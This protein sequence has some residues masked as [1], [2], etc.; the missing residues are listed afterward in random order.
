MNLRPMALGATIFMLTSGA[1]IA[2]PMP[3]GPGMMSGGHHMAQ[4]RPDPATIAKNHADHLR[5]A[6]QLTP[7]QEP[8]LAAL[9]ASMKPPAD[10][11]DGMEGGHDAMSKL[12]T[13]QRLDKMLA[14][15]DEHRAAMVDHVA[16]IKRFYAQLTPSQ[17]KAFDTM[18]N[19]HRGPMMGG[20]HKGMRG[21]MGQGMAPGHPG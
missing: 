9:I 15:M 2:Q 19:D 12:T 6:L 7:A 1:A 17:Q 3:P 16:A 10:H 21:P 4:E 18:H 13:P 11:M 14:K 8:A 20:G 5:A